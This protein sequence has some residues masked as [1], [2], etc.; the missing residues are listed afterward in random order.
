MDFKF[1]TDQQ[2]LLGKVIIVVNGKG[3]VGK[4]TICDIVNHFFRSKHISAITPIKEIAT[5]CGWDG[6]KTPKSRKFLSDLKSI[7]MDYNQYPTKY[8]VQQVCEFMVDDKT[9]IL[10]VDIRE[11]GQINLFANDVKYATGM[12]VKTLLVKSNRTEDV[13]YGNTSDDD[14]DQYPYDYTFHNDGDLDLLEEK[15]WHFFVTLFQQEHVYGSAMPFV[16]IINE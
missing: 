1:K 8:L 9:D 16:K 2:P 11:S 7:V 15:V 4:D 10:F 12:D 6:E 13:K 3:G 5:H 14:V